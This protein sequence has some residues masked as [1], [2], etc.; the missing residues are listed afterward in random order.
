MK[1]YLLIFIGLSLC[2]AGLFSVDFQA[3]K[4]QGCPFCPGEI[5]DRQLFY[6]GKQAHAILT[7]KPA[8]AGHVLIIPKR[9]VERFEQLSAEEVAD[10]YDTIKKVDTA[11]KEL[12]GYKDYVLIQ[13][14]GKAAGQSVPHLHFHYVPAARF[15]AFR[16]LLSSWF[17]PL[18]PQEMKM[19]KEK[20]SQCL[21][22]GAAV[23]GCH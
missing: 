12:Y 18:S 23:I 14:N 22:S 21:G 8:L 1:K 20:L 17:K 16:Y 10:I 19:V 6:E 9:H 13:K 11:V 5:L 3:P 15:L 7:H 2:L 4:Q